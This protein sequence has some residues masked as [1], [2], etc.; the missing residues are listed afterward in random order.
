MTMNTNELI[1]YF[2]KEYNEKINQFDCYTWDTISKTKKIKLTEEFI[3]KYQN[4]LN[5]TWL[6]VCQVLSEKI[7]KKHKSQISW[8]YVITHQNL[9]GNFIHK[10]KKYFKIKDLS[11]QNKIN[12]L[13]YQ[14]KNNIISN[15]EYLKEI[16]KLK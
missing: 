8:Y 10:S 6:S 1:N 4:K 11:K 16:L 7:I 9:S 3:E 13:Q 5:F 12:Y 14:I 15:E 2:E